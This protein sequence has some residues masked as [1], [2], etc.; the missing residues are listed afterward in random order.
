MLKYLHS[1]LLLCIALAA[2]G[3]TDLS[4]YE[5][6]RVRDALADSLLTVTESTGVRMDLIEDGFRRISVTAPRAITW[7]REN[8]QTETELRES[9]QVVVRDS[10]GNITTRVSSDKARYMAHK[11]EFHFMGD[12][13]VETDQN[14]RLYSGYLEWS[15][16]SRQIRTPEFVIIVTAADSITGFGLD[17]SDDLETYR[18][19]EISGEFQIERRD[20]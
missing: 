12:V 11:S 5:R 20:P 3:C 8:N 15:Q 9:V 14:R 17:G 7:Q 10:S 4:D 2:I 16:D 19:R 13:F 1:G 6:D 18:L